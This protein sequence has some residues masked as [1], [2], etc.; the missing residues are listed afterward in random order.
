VGLREV[1]LTMCF[2]VKLAGFLVKKKKKEENHL[3]KLFINYI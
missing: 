2:S 1:M 3:K